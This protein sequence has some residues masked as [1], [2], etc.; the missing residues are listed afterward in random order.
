LLLAVVGLGKQ[1]ITGL[2]VAALAVI[3]VLLVVSH[4]VAAHLPNLL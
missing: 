3:V 4:Q 2:L 1:Q